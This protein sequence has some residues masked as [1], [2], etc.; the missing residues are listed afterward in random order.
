MDEAKIEYESKKQ[1]QVDARKVVEDA[2]AK[3][4]L[5]MVCNTI[6]KKVD[7][8]DDAGKE[9]AYKSFHI[10]SMYLERNGVTGIIYT[11]SV[12]INL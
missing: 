6:Y 8:K 5:K 11:N 10:L 1:E 2:V 7:E 9:K 3:Q 4:Y 12:V